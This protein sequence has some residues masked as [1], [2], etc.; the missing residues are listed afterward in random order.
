MME[1]TL[2][3]KVPKDRCTECKYKQVIK[4]DHNYYGEESFQD[5]CGVFGVRIYQ[6]QP[7][8]TC[9]EESL[10]LRYDPSCN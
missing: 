7:C 2:I 6:D 3:L 1:R 8:K 9:F 4:I 5:M 10:R